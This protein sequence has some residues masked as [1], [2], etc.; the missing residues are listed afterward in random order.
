MSPRFALIVATT[1]ERG[2]GYEGGLNWRLPEDMAY[3][4]KATIGSGG[5]ENVV[6]MG[7]KTWES[8]PS[9]FRPMQERVNMVISRNKTFDLHLVSS[10][11]EALDRVQ[12]KENT[13]VFVIGGAQIYSQAITHPDCEAILLTQIQAKIPCDAFFPAIDPSLFTLASH[14][15]L[16]AYLNQSVTEGVQHYK[17]LDF[18][19]TFYKKKE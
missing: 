3:F 6:I 18:K 19:F 7:R 16:E 8:I 12:V 17:N 1:E 14:Q 10:L 15:A 9:R 13:K 5:Y 2:I 11:Q 4:K